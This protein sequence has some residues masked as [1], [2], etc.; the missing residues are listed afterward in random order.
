MNLKLINKKRNYQHIS[1]GYVDFVLGGDHHPN[2][3]SFIDEGVTNTSDLS[4]RCIVTFTSG[5][6]GL[7]LY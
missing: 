4:I 7:I 5:H 1:S 3:S 6:T 2:Q